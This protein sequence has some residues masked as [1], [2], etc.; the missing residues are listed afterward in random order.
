MKLYQYRKK[1]KAQSWTKVQH[2]S[3][4]EVA[5]SWKTFSASALVVQANTHVVHQVAGF[6]TPIRQSHVKTSQRSTGMTIF[7]L[8]FCFFSSSHGVGL[9]THGKQYAHCSERHKWFTITVSVAVENLLKLM[10]LWGMV[11]LFLCFW[12]P[13]PS[14]TRENDES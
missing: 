12:I 4:E 3:Q 5:S 11:V 9:Q 10:V 1:W 6:A 13:E 14:F 8:L 2:N 7:F